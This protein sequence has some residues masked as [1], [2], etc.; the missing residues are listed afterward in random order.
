MWCLQAAASC[1]AVLSMMMACYA[2]AGL[3]RVTALAS[4]LQLFSLQ[5]APVLTGST[6]ARRSL[7]LQGPP[8]WHPAPEPL[9]QAAAAAAAAAAA[10]GASLP[11][12][13]IMEAVKDPA[14]AT[15][16][17]GFCTR[18]QVSEGLQVWCGT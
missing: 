7:L 18:Q 13:A 11:K 15:H 16:L 8:E 14:I 17:V 3:P 5:P 6:S 2:P 4:S 10:R 12:L 1:V 9:K